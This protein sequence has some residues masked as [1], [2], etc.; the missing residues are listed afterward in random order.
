M[1]FESMLEA[2]PDNDDDSLLVQSNIKM[3]RKK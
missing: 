2:I 1:S 3:L